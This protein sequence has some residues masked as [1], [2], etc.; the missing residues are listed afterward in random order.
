[1]SA[2]FA[3]VLFVLSVLCLTGCGPL[4]GKPT[5]AD[6]DVAPDQVKD[7]AQLFNENCAGCHGRDGKGNGA[8]ALSNPVFLAIIPD[9]A[10]RQSVA[11]G[12]PHTLMPPFAQSAG[13][14]LTDEQIDIL[15]KGIRTNWSKASVLNGLTP[16]P[17]AST[18]RGNVQHGA[19]V[20]TI[21]C[22]GCHGPNGEGGAKGGSIVNV[23]YL[24]LVSDQGLRTTV[25]AGRPELG[26][27]DWRSYLPNRVMTA[28][29]VTDVVAW[30]A[31]HRSQTP[32]QPYASGQ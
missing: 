13:G 16:P 6:V 22:A 25:I 10:I 29:E 17:F 7:F 4:P 18:A 12:V 21:F 27:P 2:R 3:L 8:L 5:P 9:D 26:H 31:S 32:G 14:F 23:S 30:L 20:N 11:Q 1:M 28:Q 19:E 15:A 24:S